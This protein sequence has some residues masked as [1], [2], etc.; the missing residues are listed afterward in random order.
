MKETKRLFDEPLDLS[1]AEVSEDRVLGRTL[2][3]GRRS[4]RGLLG[5]SGTQLDVGELTKRD[6]GLLATGVLQA[7]EG[8]RRE[9]R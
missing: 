5:G 7:L 1:L 9:G 3:L 2:G 8:S 6:D 4:R